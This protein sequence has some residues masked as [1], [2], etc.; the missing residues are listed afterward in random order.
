MWLPGG[1]GPY[2]LGSVRNLE[3]LGWE[4]RGRALLRGPVRSGEPC[5]ESLGFKE[6]WALGPNRVTGVCLQP[7]LRR[8]GWVVALKA[9]K[10]LLEVVVGHLC[11]PVAWAMLTRSAV[12]W[13]AGW[14]R[15]V[16]GA[17]SAPQLCWE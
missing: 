1:E 15:P 8:L 11:L 12:R 7:Q 10:T 13:T 17:T 2:F 6:H 4:R 9:V 16:G 3:D 14:A 5:P